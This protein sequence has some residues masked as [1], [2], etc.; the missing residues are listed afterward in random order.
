M[1]SILVNNN[2]CFVFSR[3]KSNRMFKCHSTDE[4]CSFRLQLSKLILHEDMCV[5]RRVPCPGRHRG[6]CGWTGRLHELIR[7]VVANKCVQ[8]GGGCSIASNSKSTTDIRM[9]QANFLSDTVVTTSTVH[10]SSLS[11]NATIADVKSLSRTII[12]SF[13]ITNLIE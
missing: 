2:M 11:E 8:V 12:K 3:M 10:S 6:A 1:I 9:V 7:H 4:G 13:W 5:F